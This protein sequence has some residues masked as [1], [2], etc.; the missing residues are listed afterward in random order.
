MD[1]AK[2]L[3]KIFGVVTISWLRSRGHALPGGI[4]S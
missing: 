2:M 1:G 4:G 3:E